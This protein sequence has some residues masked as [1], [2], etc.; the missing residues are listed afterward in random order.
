MI[1]PDEI[2]SVSVLLPVHNGKPYLEPC[3]ESVQRQSISNWE[4]VLVD[5]GSEDGSIDVLRAFAKADERIRLVSIPE[6]KGVTAAL[7]VGL[8]HCRAELIAR[9]DADDIC[10]PHRLERQRDYLQANP[11]I[12]AV[13]C[14]VMR[15]DADGDAIAVGR[16]P[17]EHTDIDRRL[18]CGEGGLPHPGAM[19]RAAT[20][21]QI[22]GYR[23]EFVYA[24][25]KDLWLR[26]GEVGE[27]A[28]LEE[29][30]LYYREHAL[31]TGAVKRTEQDLYLRRAVQ[32]AH[33]RRRLAP[34]HVRTT[35]PSLDVTELQQRESWVRAALRSGNMH[36]CRKHLAWIIDK[37]PYSLRTFWL[38]L[39][40]WAAMLTL[41]LLRAGWLC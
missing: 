17:R 12:V 32:D 39:R 25:D 8:R 31:S 41:A 5:D 36:A 13:G 29:V 16:W 28:N 26:L 27:L 20:L 15:I 6:R 19:I 38:Q 14:W 10:V 4:L 40:V 23:E 34:H 1:L 30:L 18:L 3:I 24:Q 21:Q 2:P 33:T 11:A 35:G 22:G 37:D 9:L 7:N